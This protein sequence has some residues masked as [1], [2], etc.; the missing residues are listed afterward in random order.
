MKSATL[1]KKRYAPLN[2]ALAPCLPSLD[3]SKKLLRACLLRA[4]QDLTKTGCMIAT[5][6][7][8]KND[9]RRALRLRT[10]TFD[11]FY[12]TE[13][14]PWTFVWMCEALRLSPSYFRSMVVKL[15]LLEW[16]ERK[17][18]PSVELGKH[19]SAKVFNL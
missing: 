3:S 11:W 8:D 10:K 12:E 5:C 4:V 17:C 16:K 19:L 15:G 2:E 14:D 1:S 18:F 9:L 6:M 7:G 13:D